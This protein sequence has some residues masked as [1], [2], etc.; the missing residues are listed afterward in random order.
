MAIVACYSAQNSNESGSLLVVEACY[1]PQNSD[2]SGLLL[3]V[4]TCYKPNSLAI[5]MVQAIFGNGN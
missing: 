2:E 4:T 3:A 1:N 5:L